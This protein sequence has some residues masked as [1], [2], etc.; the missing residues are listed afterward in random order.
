MRSTTKKWIFSLKKV[1]LKF[2]L[3]KLFPFPPQLSAKSPLM[4]MV[5]NS[6]VSKTAQHIRTID[7]N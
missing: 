7:T 4:P 5:V 3:Q 1:I 2:G 6:V